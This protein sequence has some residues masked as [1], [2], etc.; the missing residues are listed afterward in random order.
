[1]AEEAEESCRELSPGLV[2]V[3]LLS[4]APKLLS[5]I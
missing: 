1:M 5:F 3:Q 4:Q 2:L